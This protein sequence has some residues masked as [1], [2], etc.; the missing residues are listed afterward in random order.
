MILISDVDDARFPIDVA[1]RIKD[2]ISAP[3]LSAQINVTLSIGITYAPMDGKDALLLVNN[4]NLAM[5][6]E[7]KRAKIGINFT[8]KSF[9]IK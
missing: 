6:Q 9:M 3:L 5:T 7:R 8:S 2:I 4:C 1:L